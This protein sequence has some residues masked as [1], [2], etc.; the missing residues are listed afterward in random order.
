MRGCVWIHRPWLCS[1]LGGG[2][3]LIVKTSIVIRL[4]FLLLLAV[5]RKQQIKQLF[6]A[7]QSVLAVMLMCNAYEN[8]HSISVWTSLI[9]FHS[10]ACCTR[11]EGSDGAGGG[12]RVASFRWPV[13]FS[14]RCI[15]VRDH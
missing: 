14:K 8:A 4:R 3:T 6:A 2:A 12:E 5:R 11:N 15:H 1:T 9:A 13:R 7:I 10:L